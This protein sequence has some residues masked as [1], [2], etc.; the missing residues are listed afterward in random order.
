MK[1]ECEVT[2]VYCNGETMTVGLS[3]R[4]PND[5]EWRNDGSQEIQFTASGTAKRAFWI[6]RKVVL[7]VQP[8]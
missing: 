1:I 8:R 6:G 3:G 4:Q 5:A 7:T 2:R